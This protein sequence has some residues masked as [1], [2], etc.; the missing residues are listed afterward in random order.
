MAVVDAIVRQLP[1]ALGDARS[2]IEESFAEGLL[3]CPQFTRPENWQGEA[4]PAVLLSG[5]HERIRRWRH[6]Q[7]LA[8]T[9][10]KRPDLLAQRVLSEEEKQLM[11]DYW[12]GAANE[13]P[14]LRGGTSE[15]RSAP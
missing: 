9:G 6:Q 12:N 7:A 15:R 5:H 10:R 14:A 11:S 2:V 8:A 13:W 3:D 4:V 1:G